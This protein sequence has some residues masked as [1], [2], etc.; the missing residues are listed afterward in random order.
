MFHYLVPLLYDDSCDYCIPV[1]D[2]C[3]GKGGMRQELIM[4]YHLAHVFYLLVILCR[5]DTG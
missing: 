1:S 3:P 4:Q 2:S 5:K